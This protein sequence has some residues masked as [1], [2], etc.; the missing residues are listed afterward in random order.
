MVARERDA[1][2]VGFIADPKGRASREIVDMALEALRRMSHRGAIGAD[3]VTGDGAGLLV[4]IPRRFFEHTLGRSVG[5]PDLMGVVGVF[6]PPRG[7]RWPACAAVER[8]AAQE[9]LAVWGWRTVPLDPAVLG[10]MAASSCPRVLQAILRR[11]S[12]MTPR[13]AEHH[14]H[15]MRRRIEISCAGSQQAFYVTSCS[16]HTVT[17]KALVTA[18]HLS[19]FYPDLADPDFRASF[20]IM[21]QRFATNTASTW[22]RTQP[23]R[24]LCHNGEINT[25]DGN[26]HRMR[27]RAGRLGL[28][29]LGEEALFDPPIRPEGSD[30]AILDEVAEFLLKEGDDAGTGRDMRRAIAMLVPAAWEH[31]PA[32]SDAVR[33]FYRWHQAL[34]E[35]WDGPAALVFTDGVA[36]GAAQDRN[37]LRPM[38]IAI[39]DDGPVVCA[40]EAGVVSVACRPVVRRRRLG[41]GQMIVVD[42]EDGGIQLDPV[43]AV[44]ERRPYAAWAA[45][46]LMGWDGGEPTTNV[47][48]D[49]SARQVAHGFTREDLTLIMR[50][51]ARTGHEPIFSMGDDTAVPPMATT[52]RPAFSLVRQRFAQVTNPAIDH[53][54]ERS[55]MSLRIHLGPRAALLSDRPEAASLIDCPSFFLW[56]PPLGRVLDASWPVEA[57]AGGL[58]IAIDR[59]A[60][61]AVDVVGEGAAIVIVS[62][63]EAGPSRAP[64]PSLMAVG[65]INRSLTDAGLRSETSIVAD[66]DD[67]RGSHDAAS[68]IAMG[69][70][71]LHPRLT[72]AS[73]A[74][75][76][77]TDDPDALASAV[78]GLRSAMEEGVLKA[79][80][81]LGIAS[82]D[83]YRGT[84]ALDVIGLA[85]EVVERI[86]C[87]K[88]SAIG[89]KGFEDLGREVLQRHRAAFDRPLPSPA[90][91]GLVKF[92]RGGDHH[93]NDPSVVRAVHRIVDPSL[94]RL[95]TTAA[96][97]DIQVG[98]GSG[99]AVDPGDHYRRFAGL[100]AARPPIML[101]DLLEIVPAPS[102]S[103]VRTVEPIGAILT[104]FS[105]AAMSHGSI[106]AEA[107]E[108][109]AEAMSSIGGRA[110]SGEGGEDPARFR[111]NR[112]C[113][114]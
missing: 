63:A 95:R 71:G 75:A 92:R 52:P 1:C 34:M 6:I 79:M 23:F 72:I 47:P 88:R 83:S 90:N 49:L 10:P 33:G 68:L 7:A 50:S 62:H 8:A 42:P 96:A 27:A 11:P 31:A 3:G 57:G 87:S 30:S 32:M 82:V 78:A 40:S 64:I 86:F 2:G 89:G 38:R 26:V 37:G 45:T 104:R 4:P 84:E 5:D 56:Q 103:D 113:A 93:A 106:S 98:R 112:N 18:D 76:A 53:V 16:F 9:G 20:A 110:N 51:A 102:P 21:H 77:G 28:G 22:E 73:V 109:L 41:P 54:R 14:A 114:I 55:V 36:V 108:T 91:P 24:T 61:R 48:D 80:A 15:R 65:A 29:S 107:H 58:S 67:V 35:P 97:D 69:A 12:E 25:I 39:H 43:G 66:V 60:K 19:A 100:V 13:Q 17:Y 59:L 70:E 85:P 44:A 74:A 99:E 105:T 81:R 111:T 46:H 94:T 101:R